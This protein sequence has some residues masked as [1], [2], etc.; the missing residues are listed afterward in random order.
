MHKEVYL[1]A[2]AYALGETVRSYEQAS[3]FAAV[4]QASGMP[5][6]PALWGWGSFHETTDIFRLAHR[7]AAQTLA[8]GAA[9]GVVDAADI[10]LVIVAA[11]HF[12]DSPDQ[13]LPKLSGLLQSLGCS[14]ALLQG[15][16]LN[17]CAGF[18]AAIRLAQAR[19]QSGELE[20]V[21]VLGLGSMPP[22]MLR[23][24]PFALFGDAACSCVISSRARRAACRV[25]DAHQQVDWQE[26]ASGVSMDSKSALQVST[27]EHVLAR[28]KLAK[29]DLQQVFSNNLFLPVKKMKDARLGFSG[30]QLFNHNISRIGHCHVC[31]S[32]IN[33]TDYLAGRDAAQARG[34]MYLLQSD[35][36][37]HSVCVL[38]GAL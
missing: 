33:L 35:G 11:A 36:S 4:L 12:S 22:D 2:P 20:H 38:L 18:L 17:G 14:K 26:M 3:G 29:S 30:A 28:N 6:F 32:L 25:L 9:G 27:L 16:T 31:D 15:H 7:A 13:L 37:G 10:D 8:G 5:D 21:L 19:V 24:T 1:S 23:F 34:Q